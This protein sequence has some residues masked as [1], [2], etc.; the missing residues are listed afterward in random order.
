MIRDPWLPCLALYAIVC[1]KQNERMRQRIVR[2]DGSVA[3]PRKLREQANLRAGGPVCI[4][5]TEDGLLIT[6]G[7]ERDPDQWWFWTEEWQK[8]EREVDAAIAR[9]DG[10]RV[11]MS[12]E[13]FIAE[14]TRVHEEALRNGR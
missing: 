3:L 6:A 1:S 8:G 9:G 13:E 5:A 14:L 11:F 7:E 2:N 12:G 4:R 10:Q